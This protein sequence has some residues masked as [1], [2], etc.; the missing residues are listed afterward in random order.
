MN[1]EYKYNEQLQ[2]V[3]DWINK[4]FTTLFPINK[5][6]EVYYWGNEYRWIT[7]SWNVVTF[8]VAPLAWTNNPTIDYFVLDVSPITPTW[9]VTL[10]EII[11]DVYDKLWQKRS[12]WV[13]PNIVKNRVYL[14]SQIKK[15]IIMW[16]ERIRNQRTYKDVI[17]HYSFNMAKSFSAIWYNSSYVNIWE[18]Q[19][20]IPSNWYFILRDSVVVEYNSY[21]NWRLNWL[22][23]VEYLNWDMVSVWYKIP[24]WV[25]KISEV[26][27][28]WVPLTYQDIR[29]YSINKWDTFSIYT[30]INWDRY[31]FLPYTSRTDLIVNVK[32]ISK[33]NTISDDL[34]VVDIPY[35]YYEVLSYY[36]LWKIYEDRE[37]DRADRMARRYNDLLKEYKSYKSRAVDWINNT[38]LTSVLNNF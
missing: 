38:L 32:Y 3:V 21:L 35:E 23:L 37:D 10:W 18:N 6:E 12:T 24:S 34:D 7:W 16:M 19:K 28:N 30:A 17:Y 33:T 1:W 8:D 29:E 31:L 36:A 5:I 20:H 14:E 15:S 26:I 22:P 2:W 11:D 4:N 9:N 25:K 13:A 27:I